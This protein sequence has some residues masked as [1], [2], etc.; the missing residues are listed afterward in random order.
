MQKRYVTETE[1]PNVRSD[2]KRTR[3]PHCGCPDTLILHGKL[4]GYG[5]SGA[6]GKVL[7]DQRIICSNRRKHNK[8]CGHSFVVWAADKLMHACLGAQGLWRF[9]K[10]VVTLSNKAAALRT[11]GLDLSDSSA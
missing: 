7:R 1:F 2:L 8:C 5:D 11:A 9:L 10:G 6:H 4:Y 3:C